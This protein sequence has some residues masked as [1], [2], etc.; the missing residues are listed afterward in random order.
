MHLHFCI[1]QLCLA[2]ANEREKYMKE[3]S[4]ACV[5]QNY[6]RDQPDNVE[7]CKLVTETVAILDSLYL[8]IDSDTVA[9][10]IRIFSTL[11]EFT[12]GNQATR[13]ELVDCKVIDYI[14]V[15]LRTHEFP[16][17]DEQD[18]SLSTRSCLLL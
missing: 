16:D 3:R 13:I 2:V 9:T 7:S 10:V 14:N 18:V 17:C 12:S 4:D 15:I 11:N 1:W 6:I 8:N 5:L